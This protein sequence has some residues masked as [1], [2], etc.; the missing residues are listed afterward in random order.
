MSD[1]VSSPTL[2]SRR[3]ADVPAADRFAAVLDIVRG[4]TAE[5]IGR[6]IEAVD[7][8][9]AYRDYGYNSLAAVELT[10]M[11]SEATGFELPMTLLF[12]FPTPA[13]V[14][15]H[16]L[17]RIE[18][19]AGPI[20]TDE[21]D[22]TASPEDSDPIV[23]VGIACRYPGEA[24]TPQA[25]WELVDRGV[26][27]VTEFPDDRGWDTRVYHPDP[28]HPGTTYARSG[29]F[30]SGAADFDAAFFGVGPR[31][32]LAMD[33]QQRLLLEGTWEA[34][35]DAGIDPESL[36]GSDTGVF[37]GACDSDYRQ[38][39]RSSEIDLG[40]YWAV[41]SAGSVL[42]GRVAYT[43]GLTGPALTVDTACSSSLVALH[44]ARR[45]LQRGECRLAVAAGV[46]VYATPSLFVEFSRQRA[47]SVDGRCRS[48]AEGADGAGWSE[49]LGVLVLER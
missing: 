49:G 18:P 11:L 23:V 14:A 33:P 41:G 39:A 13:E 1:G 7:P 48:F 12:D 25:L 45:A 47:M 2:L 6:E 17:S 42:S 43:F 20:A 19:P 3:L 24:R 27:A 9:R 21:P 26:D 40:G 37:V 10:R 15:R 44:L 4:E 34:L 38:L 8:D 30:L 5:L 32:A 22:P 28:D 36:R 35:E 16:L 46:T 31:E 29:G